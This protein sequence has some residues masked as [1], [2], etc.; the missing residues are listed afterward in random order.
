MERHI[1]EPGGAP[2]LIRKA[3]DLLEQLDKGM[4]LPTPEI[5]TD[6]FITLLG[7]HHVLGKCI[8]V[9]KGSLETAG[10]PL[11]ELVRDN[12]NPQGIMELDE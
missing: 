3:A 12:F 11:P 2:A 7:T 9:M 10:I 1:V 4:I 8:A 6:A 5:L